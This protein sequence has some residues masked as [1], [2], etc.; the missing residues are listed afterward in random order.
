LRFKGWKGG[1]SG[2]DYYNLGFAES[3]HQFVVG[4]HFEQDGF[5]RFVSRAAKLAADQQRKNRDAR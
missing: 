5:L 3:I 1:H 4:A 2:Q